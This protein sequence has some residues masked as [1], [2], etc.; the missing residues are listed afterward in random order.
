[1]LRQGMQDTRG[2][3][4]SI[5][6]ARISISMYKVIAYEGCQDSRLSSGCTR[7]ERRYWNLARNEM[8]SKANI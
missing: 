1:M 6:G 2:G 3:D 7:I 5:Y 4:I 8:S